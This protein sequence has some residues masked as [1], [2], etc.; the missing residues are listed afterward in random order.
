M[1][2][3][4]I[5]IITIFYPSPAT[6]T[7]FVFVQ[8]IVE[9]L[10]RQGVECLVVQ[11]VPFPRCL[12]RKG[13]PPYEK[14]NYVN[15]GAVTVLRPG[16][17]SIPIVAKGAKFGRLNPNWLKYSFFKQ[18]VLRTV[19]RLHFTPDVVYGH[20]L[21]FA[22]GCAIDIAR[23]MKAPSFIGV[24]EGEFWSVKPM[25]LEVAKRHLR[26]ATGL[27]PNATHLLRKVASELGVPPDRMTVLPNGV[28]LSVFHPFDRQAARQKLG[29]PPN[30]F[31]VGA[32]GS[33]L[34]KKGIARVGQAIDG[35]DGVGGIFAGAGPEPPV[36]SNVIWAKHLPHEQL[37]LMLSACDAFVLPT[38]IEGCCNALIEA[39][40]CGV[41]IVSSDSEY[42][43]DLLTN[44]CAIRVD[45]LDVCAIRSAIVKLRDNPEHR[46]RMAAAALKRGQD[47]DINQ[48]ARRLLNFMDSTA[49]SSV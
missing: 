48:R 13:Y 4:R 1:A 43:E 10:A 39:L 25:G 45:P 27:I 37:P 11:P 40:A 49:E 29:L 16:Y 31:I 7:K 32:V 21:Y 41:P 28:D 5:L 22:G 26:G 36:G 2:I 47:Y 19:E 24:G 35:L 3:K 38:L 46:R 12:D 30:L 23:T 15:G 34:H 9:S 42:T 8:R 18:S 20:F 6:P 14:S 44:E 17:L 33:F